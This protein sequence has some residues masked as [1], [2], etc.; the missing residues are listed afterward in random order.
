MFIINNIVSYKTKILNA[1]IVFDETIKVYRK[2]LSFI[3]NVVNNEWDYISLLKAKEMINF[4]EKLIHKTKNNIPKYKDFNKLFY[5]FPSYLRREAIQTAIG[6]VSSYKSNLENYIK[7]GDL[8]KQE[9]K[10]SLKHFAFPVLYKGNMYIS[11]TENTCKIKIYKNNDWV[12]FNI[13]L[14]QQDIN[15]L[16]KKKLTNPMS[17]TLE[18]RGRSYYLRF[19]YNVKSTLNKTDILNQ[20]ILAVDLGINNSAVCS[21]IDAKG[22]VLGR[23]FINQPREKDQ[24]MHLLNRLKKKQKE[25]GTYAKNKKLWAKINNLNKATSESTANEI[26]SFAIKNSINTI[27]F[28][29]LSF[30]GKSNVK[31]LQFWQKRYIQ[32]IVKSKAHRLGIRISTINPA[33]TSKLA[34]DGSG[35]VKRHKDNYSLCTFQSGKEYNS[36]LNASYNIGARYFIR[37]IEKTISAK[38]WSLLEAKV[39]L[40]GRRIQSTLSTLISLNVALGETV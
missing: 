22:T 39:P 3:I 29:Y 32:D 17:P 34:F 31:R 38:K 27:V 30:S 13:N 24:I 35:Y 40:L 16:K 20:K 33:N 18:K 6:I 5:K 7:E 28:E 15:Y 9:P 11:L 25:S 4:T 1:N 14:R 19:S 21:V 26:I 23:K 37:E 8:T 12:W 10:L 2:A 36:D